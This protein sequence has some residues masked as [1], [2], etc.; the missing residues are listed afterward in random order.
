MDLSCDVESSVECMTSVVSWQ[1]PSPIEHISNATLGR[2]SEIMLLDS[3][4]CLL[5]HKRSL[6]DLPLGKAYQL[7]S[8]H[9][10]EVGAKNLNPY[11][12]DDSVDIFFLIKND[13]FLVAAHPSSDCDTAISTVVRLDFLQRLYEIIKECIGTV[14][15]SFVSANRMLLFEVLDVVMT[16]GFSFVSSYA[17][18][19]PYLSFNPVHPKTPEQDEIASRFFGI[20]AADKSR[21]QAASTKSKEKAPNSAYI[22][23]MEELSAVLS[24]DGEVRSCELWG[25]L[26]LI[27]TLERPAPI[28]IHLNEDLVITAPSR[29]EQQQVAGA[30]HIENPSFHACVDAAQLEQHKVLRVLPPPGQTRL[31]V[32]T[33]SQ[34]ACIRIPIL[35]M[36]TLTSIQ[37]SRDQNFNL[38]L[39]NQA[40][41]RTLA[42]YVRVKVKVPSWIQSIST[43]KSDPEHTSH[44]NVEE[45]A[46]DWEI[47]RFQGGREESISFRLICTS[48]KV[49]SLSDVGPISVAFNITHFSSSGLVVRSAQVENHNSAAQDLSLQQPECYFGVSTKAASFTILC[50][51]HHHLLKLHRQHHPQ[52]AQSLV[53]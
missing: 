25:K 29:E 50:H 40:D 36:S 48:D 37:E 10:K 11:F 52:S 41:S 39:I 1:R 12:R 32:Y 9:L 35:L 26:T 24:C 27:S 31:M 43:T 8:K 38:R 5:V 2:I 49:L 47:K 15:E 51:C 6:Q 7:F 23:I 13:I 53:G 30:T 42:S 20:N 16:L 4:C 34:Q 45:K 18:I 3:Q 28:S 19:K 33:L 14:N 44:F 22:N 17:E 21:T 46:V